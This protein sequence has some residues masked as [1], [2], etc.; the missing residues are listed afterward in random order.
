MV[1]LL[2][3]LAQSRDRQLSHESS[4]VTSVSRAMST[5]G[6][7]MHEKMQMLIEQVVI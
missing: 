1:A 2:T 3:F 7:S 5:R 6:K 4:R